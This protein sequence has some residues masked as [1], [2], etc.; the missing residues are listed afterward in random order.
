VGASPLGKPSRVVPF[1]QK[2][3]GPAVVIVVKNCGAGAVVSMMY[4]F[5]S[6]RRTQ[7]GAVRPA[8][9]ATSVK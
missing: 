8:F 3:V 2:N 9:W 7:L 5:V 1:T 6:F 4:F